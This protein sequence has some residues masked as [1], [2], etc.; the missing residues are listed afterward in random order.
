MNMDDTLHLETEFE[1]YITRKLK[2]LSDSGEWM[3]SDNDA[4]YDREHAIY[5]PDFVEFQRRLD[6]DKLEKMQERL[7]STFE[8]NVV[9]RLVASLE[10]NG[11]VQTL[12][13]GFPYAGFQTITCCAE[14]PD[15]PL[16]RGADEAYK[17]NILR[18][19]RQVHYQTAGE[20][21]LDLVFFINGIPV[22]TAEIKTEMTQTVRD[23]IEEYQNERKP[24]EPKTG[25][26]NYLLMFKRGAVVHFAISEN[27]I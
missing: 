17:A 23:A 5:F 10:A 4:G 24:I 15:N 12:R 16:I 22:A 11:T 3:V 1:K 2:G 18:V 25:R 20:K 8:L 19:M 14:C 9:K 6:P 27:E 13:K 7:G 26:K 21:S